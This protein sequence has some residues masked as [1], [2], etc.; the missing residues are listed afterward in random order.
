MAD[1]SKKMVKV[2]DF[3]KSTGFERSAIQELVIEV[4][5]ER[6]RSD[7]SQTELAAMI[8]TKQSVIS[9]FENYGREPKISS[10]EKIARVF[11]SR[12]RGTIHGDFMYV[13][14]E[15]FRECI[16]KQ[17]VDSDLSPLEYLTE[18]LTSYLKECQSVIWQSIDESPE[19]ETNSESKLLIFNSPSWS[20]NQSYEE[21]DESSNLTL[22]CLEN[23][24][25]LYEG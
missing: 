22:S 4:I 8:D 9:R 10:L 2:R 19:R 18:L 25:E 13:A 21:V 11:G 16:A 5:K 1:K 17:A 6:L 3:I 7:M 14:P 12:F 23:A 20:S 15:Q 24:S